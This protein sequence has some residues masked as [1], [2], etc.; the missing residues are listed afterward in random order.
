MDYMCCSVSVASGE[1]ILLSANPQCEFNYGFKSEE[2]VGKPLA[3]MEEAGIFK[4]SIALM[5]L[6]NRKQITSVQPNRHGVLR[7]TIGTPIFDLDGDIAFT[8]CFSAWDPEKFDD[9]RKS[10]Q[11]LERRFHAAEAEIQELRTR[12]HP[13]PMVVSTN[14]K[15]EMLLQLFAQIAPYD[16]SVLLSGEPGVG[17][18]F[19]ARFIHALRHNQNAP[20]V[21]LSCSTIPRN[22][23]YSELFGQ[24]HNEGRTGAISRAAGG[25]LVLKE[26]ETLPLNMQSHLATLIQNQQESSTAPA[27]GSGRFRLIATT[28]KDLKQLTVSG[29]FREEL[30]CLLNMIPIRIPPLTERPEDLLALILHYVSRKNTEYG[31]DKRIS[32]QAMD[33]L[34]LYR[35]PGNIREVQSL[36]GRLL[37]TT[38]ENVIETRHLPEAIAGNTA[39]DADGANFKLKE[40]CDFFEKRIIL[41]AM[42]KHKT[43]VA[44][45]KALGISQPSVVRKLAKYRDLN[46]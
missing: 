37:L 9:L 38:P 13:F 2:W 45:A 16:A 3:Q 44:V 41:A 34:L 27:S 12:E 21:S 20:F 39:G 28:D 8:V 36:I 46:R 18:A 25:T 32:E 7:P 6:E 26:V 5:V 42:E 23:L 31:L 33:R 40:A 4:P 30:Y 29:A 14:K 10:Y 35:W 43:T 22:L 17:K 1:G 24:E 11:L 19:F 15:M